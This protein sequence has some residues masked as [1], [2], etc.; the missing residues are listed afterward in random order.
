M[1]RVTNIKIRRGSSTEW[2]SANP[3]LDEG[4]P[5]YDN[6]KKALKIGDSTSNWSGLPSVILGSNPELAT[7]GSQCNVISLRSKLVDFKLVAETIIFTVPS[8]HMFLIDKMELITTSISSAGNPPSIRFGKTDSYDEFYES[9][10]ANTNG[11]GERHIIESPQN[12]VV[13]GSSITFGIT[14]ASTASSHYGFGIIT[15]FLLPLE[16]VAA[17]SSSSSSNNAV[18][19]QKNLPRDLNVSW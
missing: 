13:S 19:F 7:G 17:S 8:G 9:T 1:P 11:L 12:G 18:Y 16:D 10:Q 15:G 3:I 2:A 4:E 5:G 6:T 14:E